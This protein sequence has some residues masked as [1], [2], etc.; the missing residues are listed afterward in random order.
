MKVIVSFF[1]F[2]YMHFSVNAQTYT[3]YQFHG[4]YVDI[5]DNSGN[6]VKISDHTLLEGNSILNNKWATGAVVLNNGKQTTNMQLKFDVKENA[7]Y[8]KNDDHVYAFANVVRACIM[9]YEE[10]D[11][12]IIVLMRSGYPDD[13]GDSTNVL[14]QVVAEGPNVQFLKLLK[15]TVDEQYSYGS[16]AKETYGV[17]EENYVY[18]IHTK[19]LVKFKENEKSVKSA[20]SDYA[21][22]VQKYLTDKNVKLNSDEQIVDLIDTLN[23]VN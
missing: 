20:L 18:F 17:K 12:K 2:L 14:Y 21:S 19:Q 6:K 22:Q 1:L 16:A 7:L 3:D 10:N 9:T 5:Y 23:S 8:F 15:S 11:K 13:K 4:D